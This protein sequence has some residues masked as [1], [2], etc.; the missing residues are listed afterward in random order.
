M[1]D[2]PELDPEFPGA[3]IWPPTPANGVVILGDS[4]L[5]QSEEYFRRRAAAALA[6]VDQSEVEQSEVEQSE[7]DQAETDQPDARREVETTECSQDHAGTTPVA[8][9]ASVSSRADAR[10]E[11]TDQD[12]KQP[13]TPATDSAA[14][15]SS[16]ESLVESSGLFED[17]ETAKPQDD[18]EAE[19]E[20]EGVSAAKNLIEWLTVLVGA[21]IVALVFRSFL[22]QAFYIPSASMEETLQIDD[23]VM[24]NRLSYKLHDVNRGD[25]IVFSRPPSVESDIN[26][27]IKRVMALEGE[28]IEGHDNA[29]YVNGKLVVEPY[30]EPD[31]RISDFPA[32]VVPDGHVFVMGDNRDN[33]HD[34]RRFGP[35]PVDTIVGR[36]FIIFWPFDNISSL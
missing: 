15:G 25:V 7:L 10:A 24:V 18:T 31:I 17:E 21:V 28:T 4:D 22:F 14:P 6:E 36:A 5:E 1:N 35:I 32:Q 8:R 26:D 12:P 27:L 3:P 11:A 16:E 33:S 13:V 19:A 34:S 23:K 20:H 2:S 30:L 29:V 9:P